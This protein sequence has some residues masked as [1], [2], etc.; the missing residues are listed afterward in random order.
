MQFCYKTRNQSHTHLTSAE[1]A[2]AQIEK[3]LLAIVFACEKFHSYIYGRTDVTV[4]T[5]HLP[6]VNIFNKP[7]RLVPL[8][9]QRMRLT[10][11]QY[12]FQI[13]GKSGKD[14]PVEDGLSRAYLKDTYSKLLKECNVKV[15]ARNVCGTTTFSER[16]Q[17]QLKKTTAQ[18]PI[19]RK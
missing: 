19:L 18:D 14:I 12:S 15:C 6:L 9:L 11:Q 10:L 7:L 3:E 5:D 8:R 17:E 2:Y 16:R 4:E 1:Y 13:I